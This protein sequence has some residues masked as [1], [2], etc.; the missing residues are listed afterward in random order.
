MARR[1]G[2]QIVRHVRRERD[3]EV[4]EWIALRRRGVTTTRIARDYYTSTATVTQATNAVR[5]ADAA[6][7]G[8]GTRGAYW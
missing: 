3:D 2:Q 4:L 8:E 6:E 5:D 1:D 7:S